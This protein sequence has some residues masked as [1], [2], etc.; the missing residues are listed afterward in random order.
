MFVCSEGF[1]KFVSVLASVL[2]LGFWEKGFGYIFCGLALFLV[3]L[4]SRELPQPGVPALSQTPSRTVYTT[5]GGSFGPHSCVGRSN[6]IKEEG[7]KTEAYPLPQ[8]RRRHSKEARKKRTDPRSVGARMVPLARPNHRLGLSM[9][10]RS[11][12]GRDEVLHTVQKYYEDLYKQPSITEEEVNVRNE[13]LGL[14]DRSVTPDQNRELV[15]V[16]NRKEIE[17]I[18]HSM[19]EGKASGEDGITVE[20]LKEVWDIVGD[21]CVKYVLEIWRNS[22]Q[23]TSAMIKLLP[24]NSEHKYLKNKVRTKPK[25]PWGR[26]KCCEISSKCRNLTEISKIFSV[27]FLLRSEWTEN[28]GK[29]NRNFDSRRLANRRVNR[30]DNILT[31]AKHQ[32]RAGY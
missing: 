13:V 2:F 20:V 14:L 30:R 1:P 21:A 5:A 12:N 6:L 28:L 19:A 18:L 22:K 4:S 11:N 26:P 27:R 25:F 23:Q 32:N 16:P 17:L 9:G 8:T 10:P 3:F 15:E 31:G 29:K 7:K 24:K